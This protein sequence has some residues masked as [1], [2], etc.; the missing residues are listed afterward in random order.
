MICVYMVLALTA[1]IG[2]K[3]Y[4]KGFNDAYLSKDTTLAIKGF[5][6]VLVFCRHFKQYVSFE[7]NNLLDRLFVFADT[8][9]WQ[10]IVV[11]F[12]FYS[13]YGIL[14]QIRNK[15]REYVVSFLKRRLFPVWLNFAVCICLFIITDVILGTIRDYSWWQIALS[16][17]GWTS[18]GNSTW[19]MFDTFVLYL[20]VFVVFR[21]RDI[22]W[23]LVIF[24]GLT[25]IL[26]VVLFFAKNETWWNTILCFPLGMWY[27]Y[28]KDRI[29]GLMR[30]QLT[31]WVVTIPLALILGMVL[32]FHYRDRG[33][34]Y[35]IVSALFALFV[36]L[37][38]M[39]VNVGNAVLRF[40]GKHLF[41]IYILQRI[42]FMI[43]QNYIENVYLFFVAS[44]AVTL[45]M[46]VL[47]D[48]AF[49]RV[50]GAVINR[51][52]S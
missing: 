21:F 31:Y 27:G 26:A 48:M 18:I 10:L 8:L 5:F 33:I 45:V 32:R 39:K 50:K 30:K 41:S 52:A 35:V 29:D 23:N 51:I 43:F 16:F 46:A 7:N 25:T 13:G 11:M 38:T 40:L 1:L 4:P 44:L 12:L 20:L 47:Y 36:T 2:I 42:P 24:T 37:A 34:T 15:G 19:F 17:T 14:V 9:L 28:Y 6:V 22:K 3:V 49:E